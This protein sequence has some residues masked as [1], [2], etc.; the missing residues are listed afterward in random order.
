[1]LGKTNLVTCGNSGIGRVIA[2][3]LA[4]AGARVVDEIERLSGIAEFH[5]LD[6]AREDQVVALI[7]YPSL[8]A[9]AANGDRLRSQRSAHPE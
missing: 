6:L 5:A 7:D 9:F 4:R 2:H 8:P 3:C 1:V